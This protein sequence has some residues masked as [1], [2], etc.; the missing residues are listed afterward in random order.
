MNTNNYPEIVSLEST[1]KIMEQKK[2]NFLKY[3]G[4]MEVKVEDSFVKYH[5]L[6]IKN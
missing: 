5:I 2:K 1:E 6:I 4:M 3:V